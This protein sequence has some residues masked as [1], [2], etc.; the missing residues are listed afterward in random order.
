MRVC[1]DVCIFCVRE[2]GH[3]HTCIHTYVL[4]YTID[5]AGTD[6]KGQKSIVDMPVEVLIGGVPK[7]DVI[8][9]ATEYA[10]CISMLR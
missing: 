10:K 5:G 3:V 7:D 1:I 2:H 6:Q 4:I 8:L 9:I